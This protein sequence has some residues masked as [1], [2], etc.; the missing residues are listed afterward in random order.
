MQPEEI[1]TFPLCQHIKLNGVRCGSPA[2][3]E[4]R[5][6]FF[7]HRMHDLR[8]IR[9]KRETPQTVV[10]LPVLEDANAVQIAV[11]EVLTA[12]ND[13]RLDPRRAGLMLYGLNTAASNLK[14]LD[15]EPQVLRDQRLGEL[16]SQR[17]SDL[18]QLLVEEVLNSEAQQEEEQ[19]SATEPAM[20]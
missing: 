4:R 13:G 2:L 7:H 17:E 20:S 3:R 1:D 5:Y 15:F 10:D 8:R 14:R 9:R 11:Q 19:E 6:C 12:V 16:L 18:A